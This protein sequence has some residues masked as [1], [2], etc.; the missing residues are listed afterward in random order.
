ME[1]VFDE[2]I[3]GRA[4]NFNKVHNWEK[5]K[6][7][8]TIISPK[9]FHENFDCWKQSG[10]LSLVWSQLVFRNNSAMFHLPVVLLGQQIDD[11]S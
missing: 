2:A 11:K 6:I 10:F 4:E 9:M 8:E 5:K 7:D 3:E 1:M